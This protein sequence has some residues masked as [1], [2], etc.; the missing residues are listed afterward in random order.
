MSKYILLAVLGL[1]I[2]PL[3]RASDAAE[4]QEAVK[5]LEE[6]VSKT[7]IFDLPS[8]QMTASVQVENQ[9][10]QLEGS[11]RLL[12]NGRDQWREEIKIPGYTELQVGGKGTIWV[13]RSTEFLP[14]RIYQL[15]A[16]LGFWSNA[17]TNAGYSGY[18]VR[19]GITPTDRVKKVHSRKQHGD[20]LTCVEV[21]HETD[22]S[23]ELCVN[24]STG[25]LVRGT[26][27]EEHDFQP[28][29]GKVFPRS[30][31]F[32]DNGKT[33][34]KISVSSLVTPGEFPAN[35]FTPV[36]GITAEAGCMNP[37]SYRRI[38]IVAPQYPPGLRQRHIEGMAAFDVS[39]N[40]AGVPRIHKMVASTNPEF[41]RS[42]ET[43]I[44]AWRYEP[45]TCDG[46]PVEL[47]TILQMKFT[48]SP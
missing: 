41:E 34:V 33:V 36:S 46:K 18:L 17:S 23:T 20:K 40:T 25:T 27:Y 45:A 13:R 32:V 30:L 48:L 26:S 5:K 22:F 6:A 3:L 12:W 19:V 15:H 39:I 1:L 47:E 29:A 43:A 14:L 21:E 44:M 24:D 11:Y 31:S 7:N 28:V 10:E 4:Q 38:K 37:T 9:G 35:A 2:S 16:A 42:T 8:F